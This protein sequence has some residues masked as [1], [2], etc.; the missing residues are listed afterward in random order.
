MTGTLCIVYLYKEKLQ[1]IIQ[2]MNFQFILSVQIYEY[3]G[4]LFLSQILVTMD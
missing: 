2:L 3:Y 4:R 1:F